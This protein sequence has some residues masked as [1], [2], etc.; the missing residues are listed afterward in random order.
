MRSVQQFLANLGATTLS[1]GMPWIGGH[2]STHWCV[3]Y[4]CTTLWHETS[5]FWRD[6]LWPWL[7]F[8]TA[9]TSGG[10]VVFSSWYIFPHIQNTK[11]SIASKIPHPKCWRHQDCYHNKVIHQPKHQ[12]SPILIYAVWVLDNFAANL[13]TFLAYKKWQYEVCCFLYYFSQTRA[14]YP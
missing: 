2:L 10:G 3:N 6:C 4:M 12:L 1:G 8:V 13:R 7:I 5:K 14:L 9:A 11:C